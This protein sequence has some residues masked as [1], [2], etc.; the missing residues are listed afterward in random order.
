MPSRG[1]TTAAML[2]EAFVGDT[3]HEHVE[4]IGMRHEHA[5]D[6]FGEH[7]L[8]AGVDAALAASEQ[9]DRASSS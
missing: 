9:R 1:C 8:A 4:H 3:D 7:L 6:L 5:L 2:A